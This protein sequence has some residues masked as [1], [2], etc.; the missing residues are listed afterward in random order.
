[1]NNKLTIINGSLRVNGNT[2]V[3]IKELLKG[4]K[5]TDIKCK[6]IVLRDKNLEGCKGCYY[7][8][9][10]SYCSIMDDM[11]EIHQDLQNSDLLIFASP[12]YWWGVTGLMKTYIDRLYL[13]YSRRNA[14]L[15]A[16]KKLIILT[17]M[18]VNE[19]EHGK[20]AFI[21]EI[22]PLMKTSKYIFARLGIKIK[23]MMFF[24][25]LN[26]KTDAAKNMEYLNKIFRLGEELVN[27]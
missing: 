19:I 21:S 9:K 15:I 10:H 2:D 27:L 5:K 16:G 20:K 11:Q 13:Y 3:L 23:S 7:C 26:A 6:H 22:E 8:Y 24:E 4:T 17:P 25:G 1:M 12:L 14:E 18:H